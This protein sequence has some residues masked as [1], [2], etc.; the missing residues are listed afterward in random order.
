MESSSPAR[1]PVEFARWSRR[2]SSEFSPPIEGGLW[3]GFSWGTEDPVRA[4]TAWL[5]LQ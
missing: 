1:T 2:R 5:Q 4:C 3:N